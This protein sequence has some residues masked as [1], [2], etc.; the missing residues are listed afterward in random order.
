MA[1]DSRCSCSGSLYSAVRC[2]V[3]RY[4][5][6]L[7]G[8]TRASAIR[9]LRSA[10][11]FPGLFAVLLYRLCHHLRYAV[12]QNIFT[13]LAYSVLWVAGRPYA[14]VVGIE[15]DVNAHIG[16]GFFINHFGGI[17]VTSAIIGRNCNMSQS[18]T[19]GKSSRFSDWELTD[20]DAAD[21]P[22]IGDRVWIGPG[23]V[24]AGPVSIGNDVSVAANSLVTRDVPSSGV[25]MGVPAEII[26]MKG[27]FGQIGYRGMARDPDR[28]D[29]LQAAQRI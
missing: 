19:I 21:V 3:G 8:D 15:I 23:A 10:V 14:I 9:I 2:D 11:L 17:I 20:G 28:M 18:V 22:T 7:Y 12:R 24:I 29:A 25:A 27:S 5:Y 6:A 4:I 1:T 13:R 16:A 26:S